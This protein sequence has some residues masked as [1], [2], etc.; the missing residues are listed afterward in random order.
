MYIHVSFYKKVYML[1]RNLVLKPTCS[2]WTYTQ[3]VG[4]NLRRT[5]MDKNQGSLSSLENCDQ[6]DSWVH[7]LLLI[8]GHLARSS[9]EPVP[10][11]AWSMGGN[12][13]RPIGWNLWSWH[14]VLCSVDNVYSKASTSKL[15][16]VG[17]M[18]HEGFAIIQNRRTFGW[19][20]YIRLH[21]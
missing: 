5:T 6:M 11:K 17:D 7:L 21:W 15:K 2:C 16:Y 18:Q 14:V 20:I 13:C 3:K 12:P 10:G 9:L 8:S 4:T 1:S 19:T